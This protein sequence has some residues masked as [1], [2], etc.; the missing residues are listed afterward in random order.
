M[1]HSVLTELVAIDPKRTI[2]AVLRGC[3]VISNGYRERLYEL[4]VF[5]E[6]AIGAC[7][8]EL[9]NEHHV[10]GRQGGCNCTLGGERSRDE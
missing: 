1:R 7:W 6:S 9:L 2:A 5:A 10:A 4:D 3:N 8:L